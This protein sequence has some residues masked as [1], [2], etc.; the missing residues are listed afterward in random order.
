VRLIAAKGIDG[1]WLLKKLGITFINLDDSI[2][3]PYDQYF[4]FFSS[5]KFDL[6]K[7]TSEDLNNQIE[8]LS[9]LSGIE[10]PKF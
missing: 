7:L 5:P 4:I 10:I 3:T 9:L 2:M 1:G 8:T 6:S